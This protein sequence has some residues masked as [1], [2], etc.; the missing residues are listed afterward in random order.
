MYTILN[1]LFFSLIA[2]FA[3]NFACQSYVKSRLENDGEWK[4]RGKY[5]AY[6]EGWQRADKL[7][8]KNIMW[9]W[10]VLQR[11]MLVDLLL[12]VGALILNGRK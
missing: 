2:I 4:A 12:F 1:I 10:L 8:I 11:L 9:L 5:D 3:G 6:R 7:D